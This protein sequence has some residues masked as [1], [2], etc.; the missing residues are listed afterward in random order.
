MN[1]VLIAGAGIAIVL[2][3][4]FSK[5]KNGGMALLF[6]AIGVILISVFVYMTYLGTNS[7]SQIEQTVLSA[8]AYGASKLIKEEAPGTKIIF[9]TW[10]D[11]QDISSEIVKYLKDNGI[12]EV[13]S[14]S[15]S[16]EQRKEG[17][18]LN[19]LAKAF[20]DTITASVEDGDTVYVRGF[21]LS[22]PAVNAFFKS[23][24]KSK[25]ILTDVTENPGLTRFPG[26][27]AQIRVSPDAVLENL[28][29]NPQKAFEQNFKVVR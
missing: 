27:I 2:A 1:Y 19:L 8:E 10:S 14:L 11:A 5:N 25:L 22:E 4:K 12:K 3:I 24:P 21:R 20:L 23:K 29:S 7:H 16:A 17:R 6:S 13:E 26:V 18:N 15:C 9:I 28:P